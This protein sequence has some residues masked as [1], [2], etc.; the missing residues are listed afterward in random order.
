MPFANGIARLPYL[1]A[2]CFTT[3][4]FILFLQRFLDVFFLCRISR[5]LSS[6]HFIEMMKIGFVSHAQSP[7]KRS[8]LFR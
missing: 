1:S 8:L 7:T 6:T 4:Q 3:Q 5:Q 2:P